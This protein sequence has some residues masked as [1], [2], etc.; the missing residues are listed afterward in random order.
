MPLIIPPPMTTACQSRSGLFDWGSVNSTIG[1]SS[2]RS[3]RF[4]AATVTR[5]IQGIRRYS[6]LRS[7]AGMSTTRALRSS[8][9]SCGWSAMTS[10]ARPLAGCRRGF[11]ERGPPDRFLDRPPS[12]GQESTMA[13]QQTNGQNKAKCFSR[14]H[15][16]IPCSH[17]ETAKT[18]LR[19]C[20]ETGRK[21]K[22]TTA[23]DG[24]GSIDS[25]AFLPV[26]FKSRF[27][28]LGRC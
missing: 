5:Q 4:A 27:D 24:Q 1:F 19:R 25:Q 20:A 9:E 16:G 17:L 6:S 14:R 15:C 28:P 10:S 18:V 22:A 12:K 11:R 23:L 3:F 7:C 8:S 21:S 26:S 13:R 2:R